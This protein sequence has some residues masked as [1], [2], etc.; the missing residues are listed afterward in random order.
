[1]S[2]GRSWLLVLAL[3]SA[4][5]AWFVHDVEVLPI[6]GWLDSWGQAHAD[7]RAFSEAQARQLRG[8]QDDSRRDDLRLLLLG[9]AAGCAVAALSASAVREAGGPLRAVLL[10][11]AVAVGVAGA[12]SS[13]RGQWLAAA[14]GEWTLGDDALP[15]MA[16]IHAETL[17]GWRD[18]VGEDD[19]V[20]LIGTDSLLSN[21][22]AWALHPRAMYPLVRS[23]PEGTGADELRDA[24]VRI[25]LGAEH[26]VR[27]IVDLGALAAGE[28]A[29]RPALLRVDA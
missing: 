5:A 11:G 28:Q 8:L 24:V 21:V 23:V 22:T 2:R 15:S 12:L 14:A 18:I 27:W 25:G 9:L 26:D 1:M 29:T 3:A 7:P 19:G 10:G 17:R 6:A 16:G 20:I 13:L 4:T